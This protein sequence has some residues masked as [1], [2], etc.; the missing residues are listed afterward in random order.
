MVWLLWWVK[1]EETN[2]VRR[3]WRKCMESHYDM[4]NRGYFAQCNAP[5]TLLIALCLYWKHWTPQ[6]WLFLL[7]IQHP[8]VWNGWMLQSIFTKL[9]FLST[10]SSYAHCINRCLCCKVKVNWQ[11]LNLYGLQEIWCGCSDLASLLVKIMQ[12]S[13]QILS[14]SEISLIS[15][16]Q[17]K[18]FT[19]QCQYSCLFL[20]VCNTF[21][22]VSMYILEEKLW[23]KSSLFSDILVVSILEIVQWILNRFFWSWGRKTH[24]VHKARCSPLI[25]T[26]PQ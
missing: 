21:V 22:Y 16:V 12:L 3:D 13:M 6:K 1:M 10:S 2:I 9:H 26:S 5:I 25:Q 19:K 18:I 24:L 14:F 23:F 11:K 7:L 4:K 15:N 20:L 17:F 8:T